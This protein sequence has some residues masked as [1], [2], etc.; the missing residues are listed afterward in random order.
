MARI[1]GATFLALHGL[2]HAMGFVAAWQIGTLDGVAYRTTVLNGAVDVGDAGA[3][4]LGLALIALVPAFVGTAIGVAQGRP[5]AMRATAVVAA[6]SLVVCVVG[7]PDAVI[8][9]AVNAAILA[10]VAVATV[11]GRPEAHRSPS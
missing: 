2:V 10:V 7:L 9:V 1:A 11:A 4:L 6:I 8:G 5:W 3:R